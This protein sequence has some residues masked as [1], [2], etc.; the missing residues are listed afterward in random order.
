MNGY[1]DGQCQCLM[2]QGSDGNIYGTAAMGGPQGFGDVFALNVALA[3]P[4][5]WPR[6]LTPQSGPVGTKVLIWGANLLSTSAVQ[7]NGVAATVVTNSGSSHVW[8]T[9]PPGATTGPVTVTTPGGTAATQ[10]V[11]TVQ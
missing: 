11:F 6:N 2:M 8:A 5:P 7:F 1:T 9:V 3:K 10:S 4:A